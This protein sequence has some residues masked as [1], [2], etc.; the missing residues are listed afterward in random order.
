MSGFSFEST[1]AE[2]VPNGRPP[3]VPFGIVDSGISIIPESVPFFVTYVD[4][5]SCLEG[6][7]QRNTPPRVH[8]E[9]VL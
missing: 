4:S 7:D 9:L 5:H 3:F 2:I 8:L 6:G 1:G